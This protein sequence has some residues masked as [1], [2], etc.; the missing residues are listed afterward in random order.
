MCGPLAVGVLVGVR[1]AVREAGTFVAVY[2]AT[3]VRVTVVSWYED[4]W[5]WACWLEYELAHG[6][7]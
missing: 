1:V 7:G 4:H 6:Y 5:P 3:V 2:V